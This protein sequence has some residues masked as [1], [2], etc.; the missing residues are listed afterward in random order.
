M[1]LVG[2]GRNPI[3]AVMRR[4]RASRPVTVYVSAHDLQI[5][6][7]GPTRPSVGLSHRYVL[8]RDHH[9]ANIMPTDGV[10]HDDASIMS[11]RET[12]KEIVIGGV[13]T[14]LPLCSGAKP[15]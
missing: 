14:G 2:L 13:S 7:A 9:C 15:F 3:T 8:T 1:L 11:L 12:V 5:F 4:A 10:A 6:L